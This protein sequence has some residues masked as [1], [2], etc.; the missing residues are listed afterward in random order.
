M[1]FASPVRSRFTRAALAVAI[2]GLLAALALAAAGAAA[3][4]GG[5]VAA[6]A[7]VLVAGAAGAVRGT[8]PG[9]RAVAGRG[10]VWLAAAGFGLAGV[11]AL[12]TVLVDG[13]TASARA[14]RGARLVATPYGRLQV[15]VDGPAGAPVLVL[16]HGWSCSLHWWDRVTP[17]LA[18]HYRVVRLDLLGF[19]GS[20]K[21]DWSYTIAAQ[22]R[23]VVAALHAIG[24]RSAVIAGHSLGGPV[25]LAAAEADRTLVRGL[26]LL[27][28]ETREA[29]R[30]G[31]SLVD[32]A[33]QLPVVAQ[34][35]R[36]TVPDWGVRIVLRDAFA[37]GFHIPPGFAAQA[38]AD[39]RRATFTALAR[40]ADALDDYLEHGP[41]DVRLAALH[42][43]ALVVLGGRDHYVDA[44]RAAAR[45]GR[46]PDVR[47]VTLA[48][49]G[50]TPQVEAPARTAQLLAAAMR[51]PT[52]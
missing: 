28:I 17:R 12:N 11:L 47:V 7:V 21:P 10:V 45:Y 27:D 49:V 32:R 42:V 13:A 26:V 6:A 18:R 20:D 34:W 40:S 23:A 43:P 15:R 2:D 5:V 19:G 52:V 50:H 35:L 16:V 8:S 41:A 33:A 31:S 4:F 22:G 25:A 37:P 51:Q 48:G 1:S 9:R 30:H 46:V 36:R 44:A 14:E 24:V 3:G 29:D 39:Y 38:V